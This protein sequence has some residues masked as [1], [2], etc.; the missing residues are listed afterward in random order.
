MT[1]DA[2]KNQAQSEVE[3]KFTAMLRRHQHGSPDASDTI[4]TLTEEVVAHDVSPA[5]PV[6]TEYV[7]DGPLPD[8][9]EPQLNLAPLLHSAAPSYQPTAAT[10]NTAPLNTNPALN[11]KLEAEIEFLLALDLQPEPSA[12][13]FSEAEAAPAEPQ[14]I[15][16]HPF[17][18]WR[19]DAQPQIV[20]E[21]QDKSIVFP[22]FRVAPAAD[23]AAV[24]L[25]GGHVRSAVA[26]PA[27]QASEAAP[28]A[29]TTT[30][31]VSAPLSALPATANEAALRPE[32]REALPLPK[33]WEEMKAEL[34]AAVRADLD[35]VFL[36]M[37][38]QHF[39][40]NYA[41]MYRMMLESVKNGIAD[42]FGEALEG[43]VAQVIDRVW[44]DW[45]VQQNPPPES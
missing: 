31:V 14:G 38:E 15:D 35:V 7:E 28:P 12:P 24:P 10:I 43:R 13:L 29:A 41:R 19:A 9:I 6:L 5:I 26:S 30:P 1:A 36:Q 39:A 4:P 2:N 44:Q 25:P 16:Q 21:Q 23:E 33:S 32:S 42:E 37:V 3:G 11:D 45:L 27:P 17:L 40:R 8:R 18:Q 34:D 22:E 20:E